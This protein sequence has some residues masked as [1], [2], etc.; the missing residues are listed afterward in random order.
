M[1]ESSTINTRLGRT[2]AIGYRPAWAPE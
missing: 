1:A 2:A